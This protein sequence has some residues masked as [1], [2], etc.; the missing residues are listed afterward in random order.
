MNCVNCGNPVPAGASICPSC[1]T[2]LYVKSSIRIGRASDNDI[3]LANDQVSKYHATMTF[4]SGAYTISDEQSRNGTYLNGQR[5]SISRVSPG[6]IIRLAN[7]EMLDWNK[8][9]AAFSGGRQNPAP[10]QQYS[11]SP[12]YGGRRI[13]IGRAPDNDIVFSQEDVSRHHAELVVDPDGNGAVLR[14]VGSKAGTSVNGRPCVQE[15]RITRADRVVFGSSAVLMWASVDSGPRANAAP[16]VPPAMPYRQDPYTPPKPVPMGPSHTPPH[17]STAKSSPLPLILGIVA[18]VVV[19]LIAF[20]YISGGSDAALNA[21]NKEIKHNGSYAIREGEPQALA[22]RR[23]RIEAQRELLEKTKGLFPNSAETTKN[24]A[25]FPINVTDVRVDDLRNEVRVDAVASM[26]NP[27]FL[28]RMDYL[29]KQPGMMNQITNAQSDFSANQQLMN[30][31]LDNLEIA[32]AQGY[33]QAELAEFTSSLDETITAL[34]NVLRSL[35]PLKAELANVHGKHRKGGFG[36]IFSRIGRGFNK[37]FG[38]IFSGGSS[39]DPMDAVL[40]AMNLDYSG[41]KEYFAS[42][43]DQNGSRDMAMKFY[44]AAGGT[45]ARLKSMQNQFNIRYTAADFIRQEVDEN[46]FYIKLTDACIQKVLSA[47]APQMEDMLKDYMRS[48]KYYFTKESGKWKRYLHT[49]DALRQTFEM[50]NAMQ[51]L[52]Q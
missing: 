7:V 2:P 44:Q 16:Y 40:E 18:A 20:F 50:G 15:T 17:I 23:A 5:I 42:F 22:M 30:D 19:I 38:G 28:A 3:V 45:W 52:I 51:N 21:E 24:Y 13:R 14:D 35:D 26:N 9:L 12:A 6:D 43:E 48:Q 25:I 10:Q 1:Q 37:I 8:V 33:T 49:E 27:D 39:S 11:P 46:T 41:E 4:Q 32:V 47:V 36:G 29:N 34:E 31:A